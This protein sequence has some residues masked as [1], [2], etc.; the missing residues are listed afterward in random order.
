MDLD[1]VVLGTSASAP[2]A[3]RAPSATLVRR[4]GERVLI[5]CGEGTQ[6]QLLRSDAGLVDVDFILLTHL[7]ADH[8]LGLPG[9]LKTYSLRG[10]DTGL[11]LYGPRGTEKL[12][13]SLRRV[14]GALTYPFEISELEARDRV[15]VEAA[16]FHAFRVDHG[17]EALG[18][19]LVE[20]DR[21]GRFDV[22]AADRLGVDPR[23]R[24]ALQRGETLTLGNGTTVAPGD[25]LG[26]PRRGRRIVL[27]GDTA[28]SGAVV[29]AARGADVLVHESTFADADRERARETSH[30]TAVEAALAGAAADVR[31]LAL[32]HFSGRYPAPAL[33]EEARAVFPRV[34]A[35]RDFDLISVPFP[36]RG[37]PVH[38][39]RGARTG[40]ERSPD[41]SAE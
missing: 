15:P 11:T 27:S 8:I 9:L 30:S 17:A 39:V 32:T 4:G 10:R 24:G 35:L 1:L 29:E 22:E 13:A 20:D 7:H 37:E 25:V 18:Y 33:L 19:A 3:S 28:A 23:A 6:R 26:E 31:L 36:E 38:V 41:P 16:A 2:T 21:P 40:R 12:V 34:V 5:D 14:V